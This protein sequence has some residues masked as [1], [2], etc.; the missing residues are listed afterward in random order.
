M[1]MP[2]IGCARVK[3]NP[4]LFCELRGVW[5][6][7]HS[8]NRSDSTR[9]LAGRGSS[10]EAISRSRLG[11]SPVRPSL[12]ARFRQ[13][14]LGR[15]LAMTQHWPRSRLCWVCASLDPIYLLIA[16]PVDALRPVGRGGHDR[17]RA[18]PR[19]AQRSPGG[20]QGGRGRLCE[21]PSASPPAGIGD[22]EADVAAVALVAAVV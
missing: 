15:A 10:Y 13:T 16:P 1:S 8:V 9:A 3:S 5:R 6:S 18:A 2:A 17:D 12:F 19:R 20:P 21:R 4:S 7:R 11:R 14:R 22:S